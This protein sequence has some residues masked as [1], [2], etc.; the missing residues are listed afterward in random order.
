MAK[1]I[2][3]IGA[4]GGQGGSVVSA[5]L[6]NPEY[7]IRGITRNADSANAKA[8]ASKGVEVVTADLNDEASLISAFSGAH[9]I[10]A[11]TDFFEPFQSK[12]A[13]QAVEVEY[14]QGLNLARAALQTPTLEHY[15]WSTL[16]D[17]RTISN[18]AYVV[19]HFDAK[20]RIDAFI[21]SQPALLK[22]TTF[23]WITFYATN[24]FFPVYSPTFIKTMGKH[25][26]L[27]PAPAKTLIYS[28]GD[29]RVNVGIVVR[30]ILANPAKTLGGKYVFANQ[31]TMTSEEYLN[32][33]SKVTGKP[34]QYV[35]V[36]A[37]DYEKMYGT[38]GEEMGVMQQFWG[39]MGDKSWS[40]PELVQPEDLGVKDELMTT[41]D[42]LKALDFSD[43]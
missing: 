28:V 31:E 13:Q 32:L 15:I 16:P 37:E 1:I 22:K 43:F 38:W 25:A 19:P 6:K 40:G 12:G 35:Q 23:L 18:G 27:L 26:W 29:Q 17:A 4:T 7:K 34:A 2:A 36:A 41:E 21:K 39:A 30:G 42:A 14:R 10:Y 3:I 8:L 9:A 11:V 24:L 20:A 33:W 5:L